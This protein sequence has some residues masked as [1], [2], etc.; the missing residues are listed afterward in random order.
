MEKGRGRWSGEEGG[1]E[2]KREVEK[3]RGRWRGEEG[4]GEGKRKVERGRGRW[5]G[6]EG[7]GEGKREMEREGRKKE[8]RKRRN[9]ITLPAHWIALFPDLTTSWGVGTRLPKQYKLGVGTRL[10]TVRKTEPDVCVEED[11]LNNA[12][13]NHPGSEGGVTAVRLETAPGTI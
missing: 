6:E 7:G 12:L 8:S 4:G 5:R 1:G 2:G 13:V 11:H 3:G 9:A 10:N